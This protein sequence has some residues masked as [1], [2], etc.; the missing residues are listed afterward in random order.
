MRKWFL[1]LFPSHLISIL[2][3]GMY[4]SLLARP[5]LEL[6]SLPICTCNPPLRCMRWKFQNE[7]CC[8]LLS[9]K[10]YIRG[11]HPLYNKL[12]V[13]VHFSRIQDRYILILKKE[14]RD[15]IIMC[16]VLCLWLH[17]VGIS[18]FD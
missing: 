14:R 2:A 9:L 11:F 6:W 8:H 13:A 15:M 4:K 16:Q 3:A 12:L 10:E 18:C 7:I 5:G 1:I 17:E